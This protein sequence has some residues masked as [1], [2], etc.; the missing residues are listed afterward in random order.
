MPAIYWLPLP[1]LREPAEVEH[2]H[3]AFS[4]WFDG[5][6]HHDTVKPYRLAPLSRRDGVWGVEV[7]LLTESTFESLASHVGAGASVRLGRV[8]TK[9][10]MP[11]VVQGESW[12]DLDSWRGERAWRVEFLTP[13]AARTTTASGTRT[14]PF[15]APAVVLRAAT[16]AWAAFSG[17]PPVQVAP[18][19]QAHLWVSRLDVST[20]SF[21]L[22]RHEHP[23]ALGSVLY[24]ADTPEVAASASRLFRLA[25][26]CGMGS[27]RGKGMGI[28]AVE[29]VADARREGGGRRG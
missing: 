23:G 11:L 20:T 3:A 26:Y 12:E 14:S 19:D 10:G 28:V 22:N 2:L 24:R 6:A 5:D 13:F 21:T 7:S 17:R 16:D 1:S 27:F 25:A 29:P 9:V 15:P 8:T 18:A 4:A